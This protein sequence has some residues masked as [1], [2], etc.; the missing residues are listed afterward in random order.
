MLIRVYSSTDAY[1]PPVSARGL[2]DGPN[3]CL[4]FLRGYSSVDE[5]SPHV[6]ARDIRPWTNACLMLYE[7]VCGHVFYFL[8]KPKSKP[9]NTNTY[10]C[11]YSYSYS[12][13]AFAGIFFLAI[14]GIFTAV[15]GY[16]MTVG[17]SSIPKRSSYGP[18]GTTNPSWTR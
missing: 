3:I 9:T 17:Y 5:H 13:F 1:V 7:S 10:M 4:H 6:F 15:Y 11:S 14:I 18:I 12:H 2:V 16:L 8:H